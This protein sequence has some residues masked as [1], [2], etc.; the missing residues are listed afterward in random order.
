MTIVLTILIITIIKKKKT[1][2]QTTPW[3]A[4]LGQTGYCELFASQITQITTTSSLPNCYQGEYRWWIGPEKRLGNLEVGGPF[5][6]LL[7][8]GGNQSDTDIG[9]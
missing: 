4:V 6:Q 9:I 3:Q 5:K 1:C 2:R 7:L 8:D